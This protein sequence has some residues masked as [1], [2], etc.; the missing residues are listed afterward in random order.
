MCDPPHF[1]LQKMRISGMNRV[2]GLPDKVTG[3]YVTQPPVYLLSRKATGNKT[4]LLLR[5]K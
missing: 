1:A 4:A 2:P 5:E 3:N